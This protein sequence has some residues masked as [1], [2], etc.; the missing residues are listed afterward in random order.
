MVKMPSLPRTAL[1]V[2]LPCV[3]FVFG[4][5]VLG[6]ASG[7]DLVRARLLDAAPQDRTPLNQ[8]LHYDAAAVE[9][10]WQVLDDAALAAERIFLRLDLAFPPLYG[11]TLLFSLF[12]ARAALR[13]SVPPA[14]LAAPVVVTMAADWV[15]NTVLLSQLDAFAAGQPL[16]P[17]S[18][19][20]ASAATAVK[21]ISFGGSALL[22]GALA[23]RMVADRRG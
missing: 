19:A 13:S 18:I 21:L 11:G 20:L 1:V 2:A 14:L 6:R 16:P 7:R 9:R 12:T 4:A 5:W 8:R 10:H 15:E 17:S 23:W 22:L 3:A